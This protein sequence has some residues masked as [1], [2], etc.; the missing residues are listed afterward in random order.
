MCCSEL[1][2]C[3]ELGVLSGGQRCEGRL[4]SVVGRAKV[5]SMLMTIAESDE[6]IDLGRDGD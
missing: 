1:V 5:A 2:R 4:S 3:W 6:G